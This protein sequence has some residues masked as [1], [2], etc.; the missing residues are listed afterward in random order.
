MLGAIIGDI[1]GS[2]FE[3]SEAPAPQAGFQLFV[4][5][6]DCGYTDDTITTVAIADAILNHKSYQDSLLHWCHKYPHPVG[7]YGGKFQDWLESAHPQP[8]GSYGNGSA[9]RVSPVGWLFNDYHEVL[10]EAKKSAECSHNSEEG[11]NGAQCVATLIYWLRTC[12]IRRDQIENAVKRNF[13]Y[14]IPPLKDINRI[15]RTGHID[16]TCNET[17]PWAIR[18]FLESEDF[19]D[20][21]RIAI[22]TDGDTDTKAD[23]TGA[24]AEAYYQVPEELAGKAFSYLPEDMLNIVEQFCTTIQNFVV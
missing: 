23:I 13:G 20:A 12:R 6:K 15:G 8:Y 22:M 9:M 10:K 19:E 21:I 16:T 14:S 18:C 1:A 3:A 24:I 11:I 5:D 2:R 7:A 17:V 4:K